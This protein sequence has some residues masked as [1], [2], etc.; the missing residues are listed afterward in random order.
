MTCQAPVRLAWYHVGMN[1]ITTAY[2]LI[3]PWYDL[4]HASF[5]DDLAIYRSFAEATGGPLLEIGCG[6]GRLLVP[7][8]AAGYAITGVDSSPTMLSR[9]RAALDVAGPA[10]AARVTLAQA[11][12]T[13][14][15][16]AAQAFHL[17]FI[18]LGTF[19]H[20]TDLTARR[21]TLRALRAHV[22]PGAT[23]VLDLA[24]ADPHRFAQFA[25]SGQIMHV[26]TWHD[27][28]SAQILT[29]SIAAR[30]GPASATLT[31]THWYDAH[32][33]G[34]PLTRTCIETTLATITHAEIELLLDTTGWRL[35]Q[36]YGDHDMGEWDDTSPRLI[37]VAQAAE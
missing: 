3:A 34:G 27:D 10:V 19:Q 16:L 29:H 7:L 1:E 11:D 24:Q 32:P 28:A 15:H 2:D 8:A 22:V 25:E 13:H 30:P 26:G 21:M 35:R 36:V 31:L 12:M 18:A 20:L 5:D 37:V 33:Q 4:E 6:S 9:C 23:L 14:L 17:V